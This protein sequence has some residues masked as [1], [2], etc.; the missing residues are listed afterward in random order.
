MAIPIKPKGRGRNPVSPG[1]QA[2]F[3]VLLALETRSADDATGALD[4]QIRGLSLDERDARLATALVF[5]TLRHQM[6]LDYHYRPFLTQPPSRLSPEVRVLLRIATAQRFLF[7]RIP[8]HAIVN[9]SVNAARAAGRQREAAFVNAIVRKIV[10]AAAL[11]RVECTDPV[12]RLATAQS[13]P[14]WLVELFCRKFGDS[15]TATLLAACNEEPRLVL[16][17]NTLKLTV[18]ECIAALA[19]EG[20]EASRCSIAAEGIVVK[21]T[22][23]L[24]ALTDSRFFRDGW[25]YVQDEASQLVATI[26]R[27]T[28]E[29]RILDL[30]SAPGGKCTHLA[31]LSKGVARIDATDISEDRLDTVRENI[32]RL[33]T[34]N[35]TIVPHSQIVD[36]KALGSSPYDL[37]LVDA[38]CSGLGT[39]RR[40]PEIRYKCSREA[41]ERHAE[42]QLAVLYEAARLTAPFGRIVYS[43]CSVS[44]DE[45]SSAVAR[46]LAS[47]EAFRVDTT[48]HPQA[49][50][51]KLRAT[52][53]FFRTWPAHPEMDGFEAVVLRRR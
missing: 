33:A 7:E 27:P 9:E 34:P 43:T 6:H 8:P 41:L 51:E 16:R 36:P 53:G 39:I 40:N 11:R 29:Q 35:V 20:F 30:C 45:N 44:D 10:A 14:R 31:E 3:Q 13:Q 19:S 12:D 22:G 4:A 32:A 2:A 42:R 15:A 23:T 52:D 37:V 18:E 24:A 5:A 49:A 28:G 47:N 48:P 25:V 17:V 38:P 26:A 1:R 50:V 46:F 21:T